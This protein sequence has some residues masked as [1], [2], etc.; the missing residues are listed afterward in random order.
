M[1]EFFQVTLSPTLMV[2]ALGVN[3]LFTIWTVLVSAPA[4]ATT[5]S[6]ANSASGSRNMRFIWMP[7]LVVPRGERSRGISRCGLVRYLPLPYDGLGAAVR[8]EEAEPGL[9]HREKD[10]DARAAL[11]EVARRL[12]QP[13][14][15][16]PERQGR[17]VDPLAE[18][19]ETLQVE[20]VMPQRDRRRHYG[21]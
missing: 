5:T 12:E 20:V 19:R 13:A 15:Q 10:A 14:V 4:A 9:I 18:L 6:V 16:L 3:P 11:R 21:L 1:S 2:V 8:S 7:P 17:D